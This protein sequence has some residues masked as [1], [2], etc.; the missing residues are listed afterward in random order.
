[1]VKS[2]IMKKVIYVLILIFF[3]FLLLKSCIKKD[4]GF[5]TFVTNFDVRPLNVIEYAMEEPVNMTIDGVDYLVSRGE[6]GKFGGDIVTSTIGEG[7]KTFNPFN[8]N[9]A[10]SSMLSS[11]SARGLQKA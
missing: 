2:I 11:K 5:D 7:P 4:P 8:S 1:M 6:V 9:D 10:T 3:V